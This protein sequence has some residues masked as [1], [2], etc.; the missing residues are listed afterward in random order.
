MEKKLLSIVNMACALLLSLGA[1]TA[2]GSNDG[3]L[4][5]QSQESYAAAVMNTSTAPSYVL[6]TVINDNTGKSRTGC[7]TA[8][9][10]SG[11]IHIEYNL[12][13]SDAGQEK[14]QAMLLANKRHVF[15]FSKRKAL[16][17]VGFNHTDADVAEVRAALS[18]IT[19]DQLRAG[20]F[21]PTQLRSEY[22][23]SRHRAIRDAIACVLI[24]RGLSPGMGD[25]SDQIWIAPPGDS[26]A[27]AAQ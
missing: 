23:S 14:A 19:N 25:I 9:F 17:N 2:H 22:E 5:K 11:A 10:L 18:E 12:P 21:L 1:T 4:R 24:E 15:H 13:Y 20:D 7:T 16:D 8:N 6:I 3:S 26:H 27:P